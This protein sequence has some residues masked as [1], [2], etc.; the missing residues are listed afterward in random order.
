LGCRK[1]DRQ[2]IDRTLGRQTLGS[3]TDPVAP[4]GA[5]VDIAAVSASDI[6]AVGSR[7]PPVACSYE[8]APPTLGRHEVASHS[9]A[10]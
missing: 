4:H 5:F 10:T 7:G 6:W 8:A 3:D 2:H 1:A 9:L